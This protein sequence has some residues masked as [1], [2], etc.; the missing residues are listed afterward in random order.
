[1]ALG[2]S[3]P[4]GVTDHGVLSGLTDDDHV[5]YVLASG[6]R[7]M[8]VLSVTGLATV[9]GTLGVTGAITATAALSVGTTLTVTGN[10]TIGGT[11]GVTGVSTFAAQ[12]RFADGSAA[13][14]GIAFAASTDLGFTRYSPSEIAVYGPAS[15]LIA[16]IGTKRY[17]FGDDLFLNRDAANVLALRNGAAP[18]AFSVYNTYTDAASYERLNS[19][20]SSNVAF[21][22]S[23]AAGS[24]T[25]RVLAIGT[26][27]AAALVFRTAA[28]NRWAVDASGHLVAQ[29]AYQIQAAAGVAA[30]A[31]LQLPHG[32]APT[33]P[34]DGDMWTTTAGLYVRINGATVGPLS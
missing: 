11:L 31:S 17:G 2:I 14:P 8:T 34:V 28:A 1:M 4:P 12:A 15:N 7:E 9:G 25:G 24:G 10:A 27:G 18:Q 29:G 30:N 33:A 5:R 6:T 21:I 23:T 20:W 26:T 22:E 19:Y 3:S 13:A 32:V 16:I